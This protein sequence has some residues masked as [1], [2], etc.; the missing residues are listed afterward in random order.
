MDIVLGCTDL[1]LALRMEQ[2]FSCTE[3]STSE[4]RNDYE[5][6]DCSNRMSHA[7]VCSEVNLTSI[8][9][10]TWWLDSSTTTNISVSMRGRPKY[11]KPN[12]IERYIYVG[13]SKSVEVEVVGILNYYCV[14]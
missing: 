10:N 11:Q 13:D 8:P 4:Q 6:R 9:G 3:S 12:D 2:S 14:L 7:L 1:D 5:K